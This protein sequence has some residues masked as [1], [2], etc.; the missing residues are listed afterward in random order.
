[1]VR[2]L[3]GSNPN[4]T[5]I[6]TSALADISAFWVPL[7]DMRQAV[8]VANAFLDVQGNNTEL[9]E[10]PFPMLTRELNSRYTRYQFSDVPIEELLTEIRVTSATG[11]SNLPTPI[12]PDVTIEQPKSESPAI[13]LGVESFVAEAE[14]WALMGRVLPEGTKK[15]EKSEGNLLQILPAAFRR[16]AKKYELIVLLNSPEPYFSD[17]SKPENMIVKLVDKVRAMLTGEIQ[18]PPASESTL[19]KLAA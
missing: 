2:E 18:N 8:V 15:Y 10:H 12:R 14:N 3:K 13:K 19:E 1:M 7:G 5:S 4:L 6:D 17:P 9:K 11:Q 16:E